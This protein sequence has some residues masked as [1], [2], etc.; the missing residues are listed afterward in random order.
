MRIGGINTGYTFGS[1][2]RSAANAYSFQ[3][4]Q[5]P[6]Y[7][8]HKNKSFPKRFVTS[9]F[10]LTGFVLGLSGWHLLRGRG[11]LA[12][13]LGAIAGGIVATKFRD[14]EEALVRKFREKSDTTSN[15]I[16]R[17]IFKTLSATIAAIFL[18]VLTF[19]KVTGFIGLSRQKHDLGSEKTNGIAHWLAKIFNFTEERANEVAHDAAFPIRMTHKAISKT[20][21]LL[22]FRGK[23]R[24]LP[25]TK[26]VLHNASELRDKI[27]PAF[28][29]TVRT[30]RKIGNVKKSILNL[31]GLITEK[32][33]FMFAFD[34]WR[35]TGKFFSKEV[36]KNDIFPK[37]PI[38]FGMA[39]LGNLIFEL[40]RKR[41]PIDQVVDLAG[42]DQ[43]I[44]A[45]SQ[46]P[47][48]REEVAL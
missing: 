23:I 5:K 11:K 40:F 38:W 19:L 42:F 12:G 30:D 31:V 48:R 28:R 6:E 1:I 35:E 18:T 32:L 26:D 21:D 44:S 8:E 9:A 24:E 2:R 41:I 7:Q 13:S 29:Y 10:S 46:A 36:F 22:G 34:T 16:L 14:T 45:S 20:S 39:F 4:L 33:S 27:I 25:E 47:Q 15:S 17:L 37:L 3:S 43:P